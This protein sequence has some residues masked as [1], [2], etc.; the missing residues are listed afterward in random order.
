VSGL[1]LALIEKILQHL[2]FISSI[3]Y[4]KEKFSIVDEQIAKEVLLIVGS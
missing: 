1:S 3:E 2:P 4:V